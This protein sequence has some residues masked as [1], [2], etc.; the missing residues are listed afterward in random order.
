MSQQLSLGLGS[1]A[2]PAPGIRLQDVGVTFHTPR[3]PVEAVADPAFQA[4]NAR[5]QAVLEAF[6]RAHGFGRGVAAPQIG[7]AKRFIALNLGR[8][9][10]TLINPEI[11]WRSPESFTLWDDCMCFP[12]LLVRVRRHASISLRYLDEQAAA[13]CWERLDRAESELIQHECD[14]LEGILA[15]DRAEG[16]EAIISREAFE[17]FRDHFAE[18][19]DYTIQP[20]PADVPPQVEEPRKA[21]PDAEKVEETGQR[22]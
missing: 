16:P 1:E 3:G 18:M 15:T 17:Q 21:E 6:R 4:E 12:W 22:A 19:V 20:V 8:G 7:I 14:H 13:R 5:L 2:A 11:T 9:P 10:L